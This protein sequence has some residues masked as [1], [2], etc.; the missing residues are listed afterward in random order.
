MAYVNFAQLHAAIAAALPA[1]VTT[2]SEGQREAHYMLSYTGSGAGVI[3][4]AQLAR[5]DLGVSQAEL[6]AELA[7]HNPDVLEITSDK[8]SIAGDGADTATLSLRL[9]GN[10]GVTR[11]Q[12]VTVTLALNDET[13]DVAL[14]NG[15]A[16]VPAASIE[17]GLLVIQP[18][19]P[20]PGTT[21]EIEVTTP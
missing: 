15:L 1:L 7:A 3:V 4:Q 14:T 12:N 11:P 2:S 20:L 9:T 16:S 13:L 8:T 6:D 17:P 5:D 19:A 18:A 21:L 10:D